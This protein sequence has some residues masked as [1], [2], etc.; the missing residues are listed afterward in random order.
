MDLS[1]SMK[2]GDPYFLL[3]SYCRTAKIKSKAYGYSERSYRDMYKYLTYPLILLSA[4]NTILS[5]FTEHPYIVMG[6]AFSSLVLVGFNQSICPKDKEHMACTVKVEF[7][8]ISGNVKQFIMENNKTVEEVKNYSALIHEQLQ[9]WNGLSPP[10]RDIFVKK[11]EELYIDRHRS[12]SKESK[13]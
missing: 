13:V 3:R 8:E 4:T 2:N 5:G 7:G 9:I 1:G 6:I 11:A 12:H 10:I